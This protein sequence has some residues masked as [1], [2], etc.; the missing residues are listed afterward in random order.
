MIKIAHKT[1]KTSVDKKKHVYL[2]YDKKSTYIYF[3]PKQ[4]YSLLTVWTN[5]K[6]DFFAYVWYQDR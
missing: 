1:Q 2:L 6:Y 5:I 3:H 4:T